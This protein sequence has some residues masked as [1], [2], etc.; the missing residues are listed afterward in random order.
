MG[1]KK[2]QPPICI[3]PGC[4]N[5]TSWR[6]NWDTMSPELAAE[7]APY[8]HR[9]QSCY[10]KW[11]ARKEAE[12]LRYWEAYRTAWQAELRDGLRAGKAK[13]TRARKAW[14][15][16]LCRGKIN[17]GETY[18]RAS[19]YMGGYYPERYPVCTTCRPPE[20]GQGQSMEEAHPVGC[21]VFNINP[22]SLK[23]HWLSIGQS[24]RRRPDPVPVACVP[25]AITAAPRLP[26]HR[27]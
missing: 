20:Q 2:Q 27:W 1:R 21:W 19:I 4:N 10:E 24:L 3:E 25:E 13:L 15:C 8:H 14:T 22:V 17:P 12:E 9:C 16:E 5:R 18:Q 26:I 23:C 6:T 7:V 11:R